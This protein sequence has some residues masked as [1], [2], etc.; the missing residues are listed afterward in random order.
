[1]RTLTELNLEQQFK[2]EVFKNQ[3]KDLNLEQAQEHLIKLYHLALM[4]DSLI[5]ELLKEN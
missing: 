2:L 4:K 5:K 3:V 1:M